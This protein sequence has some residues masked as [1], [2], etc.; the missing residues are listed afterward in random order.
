MRSIA[1]STMAPDL[2]SIEGTSFALLEKWPTGQWRNALS[3]QTLDEARKF[4]DEVLEDA[5]DKQLRIV[6]VTTIEMGDRKEVAE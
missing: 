4:R 1:I 2:D 5:P 3:T 6:M